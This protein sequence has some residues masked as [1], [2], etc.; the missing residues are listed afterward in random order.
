[1]NK[2]YA[3]DAA[4]EATGVSAA[5]IKAIAAELACIAFD[6]EIVIE[7]PWTQGRDT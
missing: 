3:P 1:M 6:E 7:Q 4:A 5:Q 2:A